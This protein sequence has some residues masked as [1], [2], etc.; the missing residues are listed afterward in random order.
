MLQFG[1]RFIAVEIEEVGVDEIESD[2]RLIDLR[3]GEVPDVF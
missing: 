3:G 2:Q 1:C